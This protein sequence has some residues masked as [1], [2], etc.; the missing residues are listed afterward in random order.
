VSAT[1]RRLERDAVVGLV[2]VDVVVVDGFVFNG[3]L[4]SVM[5]GLQLMAIGQVGVMGGRDH[6]VLVVCFSSQELVLC[7]R[8][9]VVCG[10]TVV[11]SSVV[12]NFVFVCGCHID[13]DIW[14][15]AIWK[16]PERL[17]KQALARIAGRPYR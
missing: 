4:F 3:S 14:S 11:F 10:G 1:A 9:K 15:E 8:F 16:I 12:M 17:R 13:L 7:S 2:V 5:N 6:V